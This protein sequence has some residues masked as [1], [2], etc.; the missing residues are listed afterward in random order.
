MYIGAVVPLRVLYGPCK[1]SFFTV[2]N[3]VAVSHTMAMYVGVTKIWERWASYLRYGAWLIPD[4]TPLPFVGWRVKCDRCRTNATS[5]CAEVRRKNWRVLP[6]GVT[7]AHRKWLV[8]IEY[9]VILLMIHC[10]M[11]LSRTVF[12]INGDFGRK[13]RFYTPGILRRLVECYRLEGW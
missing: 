8:S 2:R 6:F 12:E 9:L 4:N 5:I 13:A 3:L 11:G 7:Q 10:T 1:K